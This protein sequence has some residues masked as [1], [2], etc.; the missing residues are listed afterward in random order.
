MAI[1]LD[2]TYC[3]SPD[4]VGACGCKLPNNTPQELLNLIWFGYFC[5][6]PLSDTEKKRI[7]ND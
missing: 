7:E 4:C 6:N 3:A 1:N 5:G 2:K